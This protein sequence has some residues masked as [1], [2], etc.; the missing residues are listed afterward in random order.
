MH[1]P[2]TVQKNAETIVVMA[3]CRFEWWAMNVDVDP[4][5]LGPDDTKD[6]ENFTME[7]LTCLECAR[8]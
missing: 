8:W 4:D 7:P 6:N 1:V 5:Y 2:T 3:Q